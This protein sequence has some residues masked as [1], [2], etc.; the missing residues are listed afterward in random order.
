MYGNTI[1]KSLNCGEFKRIS[2]QS[3][4]NREEPMPTLTI[5]P[6][7]AMDR[8]RLAGRNARPILPTM[9][10]FKRGEKASITKTCGQCKETKSSSQWREGPTGGSCLCNACGL[11]YRKLFLAFGKQSAK[12]Y[13]EE[14]KKTGAKRRIPRMLYGMQRSS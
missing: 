14:I 4:L 6:K 2:V 1:V 9:G 5:T 11:F 12:R 7:N 13:L 10:L 3:L 8:S